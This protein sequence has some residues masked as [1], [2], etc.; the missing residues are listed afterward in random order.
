[1][2]LQERE[3]ELEAEGY[4][5]TR[6]QREV[7][8]SAQPEPRLEVPQYPDIPR[9]QCLVHNKPAAA[10]VLAVPGNGN[11]EPSPGKSLLH[12][13]FHPRLQN[14]K[15]PGKLYLNVKITVIERT[16]LKGKTTARIARFRPAI[17][18]HAA[19]HR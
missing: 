14:G 10:L 13:L 12:G 15:P 19:Y 16:E 11:I 17:S 8:V 4:T 9:G 7:N 2:R 18:R 5:A 1:M 6:H 3:F